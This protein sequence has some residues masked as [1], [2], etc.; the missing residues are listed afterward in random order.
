[1]SLVA[2]ALP[3]GMQAQDDLYFVPTKAN[4]DKSASDMGM[5]RDTYYSGS[6][7]SIDD[8]NRRYGSFVQPL[9]SA[10]NDIVDFDGRIGVYP[11][12]SSVDQQDYK[13]TRRM[14]KFDGYD[15]RERES[16]NAGY[17]AGRASSWYLDD[18]Y[19]WDYPYYYGYYS[20]WYWDYPYYHSWYHPWYHYS[21]W[22]YPYRPS[23]GIVWGG[24]Y[25]P[26]SYAQHRFDSSN[27]SGARFGNATRSYSNSRVGNGRF[28]G[29][30][31]SS[32]GTYSNSDRSYSASSRSSFSNSNSSFSGARSSGSFSSGSGSFGG[33]RSSGSGSFGGGRSGSGS[34]GG[35]R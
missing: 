7:R 10:G 12:S 22:Y 15:W 3:L 34:F 23:Y 18:P 9:D 5:P 19:Y 28:G 32:R 31:S 20:S 17:R 35:R 2:L 4:V 21:S 30:R 11:D 26:K 16:Y 24:G 1:M 6:R 14:S 33:A 8:Y 29:Q 13:Y 27:F 25:S